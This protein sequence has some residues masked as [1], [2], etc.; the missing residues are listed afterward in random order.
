[1]HK[2]PILQI[3]SVNKNSFYSNLSTKKL[4]V[5][6][7]EVKDT[8][9]EMVSGGGFSKTTLITINNTNYANVKLNCVDLGKNS[10]LLIGISQTIVS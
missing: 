9:L 3:V 1:M 5:P 6:M 7:L 10:T 8:D 2:S 4:E